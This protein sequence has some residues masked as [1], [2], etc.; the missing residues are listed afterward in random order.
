MYEN[1]RVVYCKKCGY[2]SCFSS[3][4]KTNHCEFCGNELTF[5]NINGLQEQRQMEENENIHPDKVVEIYDKRFLENVIKPLGEFD[6][7][8]YDKRIIQQEIN[9]QNN[10]KRYREETE[11][12]LK[13]S[14][15]PKCPICNSYNIHKIS[16]GNK[17]GSALLFGVF[18]IG[19]ISKTYKCDNCGAKF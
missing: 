5:T 15:A 13:N 8:E 6:Q 9:R 12:E 17:V 4:N 11:E 2:I 7:A 16:G 1:E 18:S 10:W 3:H 19:H 14:N